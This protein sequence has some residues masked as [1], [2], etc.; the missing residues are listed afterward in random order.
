VDVAIEYKN[1]HIEFFANGF[2]NT[3]SDY[4][5]IEPDG[6]FVD[7]DA[8]FLYKQ[9]NANL[10]GGELGFHLHPHPLDWLH[11]ES[12]FESVIGKLNEGGY[13]PLIPANNWTNT[14]RVEFVSKENWLKTSYGFLT[15]QSVFDQN[16]NS[17]FETTSEGYNLLN[18]GFGGTCMIF[19][20]QVS[21]RISGNNL[22][23]ASYVSH[24]SRLKTD[25]I[26]NIG[27]NFNVGMSIAL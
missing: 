8:V 24:L 25:A 3:I 22:M 16:N 23:N 17:G 12:A 10:Y 4:I 2:Y 5:Y 21:M 13:L 11:V 6:N 18:I 9:Q 7:A 26:A 15:L 1:E 27:R 20:T 19:N 14:L